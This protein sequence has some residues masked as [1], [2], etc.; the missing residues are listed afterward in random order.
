MRTRCPACRRKG[1]PLSERFGHPWTRLTCRICGTVFRQS[2][3]LRLLWAALGTPIGALGVVLA[4]LSPSGLI[5]LAGLAA[6]FLVA[7]CGVLIP[8]VELN[9]EENG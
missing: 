2:F 7:L 5:L 8:L 1:I 3:S 6:A 9:P 4:F